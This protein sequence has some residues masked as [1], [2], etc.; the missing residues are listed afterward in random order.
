[1]A[2]QIRSQKLDLKKRNSDLLCGHY[3]IK[4]EGG[5]ETIEQ[6]LGWIKDRG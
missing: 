3:M 5:S 1:M 4:T 2:L 6:G